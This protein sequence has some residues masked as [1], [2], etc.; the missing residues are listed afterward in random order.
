MSS[1]EAAL[2]AM[3]SLGP[4]EEISYTEITKTHGVDRSTLSRRHRGQTASRTAS[5]EECRN[6]HPQQEQQQLLYINRLTE[7][8][9][10]PTRAMIRIFASQ[11]AQRELGV[12]WVDRFVQRHPDQLISE[13]TT[14]MDNSRHK[15]D[16]G[17]KYSLYFDL[18]R[19]KLSSIA[20][21][22]VTRTI[23]TRR[24]SCLES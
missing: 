6:L 18:L 2:A 22:L 15:A 12:H 16:S 21:S 5:A 7:Q 13:W 11:I 23:W 17:R 1:I 10:P 4:E 19:D 20:S 14:A 9:L 8:G 24:A 3:A